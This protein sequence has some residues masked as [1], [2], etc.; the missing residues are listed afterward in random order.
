VFADG[1][2][3]EA[4]QGAGS[5]AGL[6]DAGAG[7]DVGHGDDLAGVLGVDDGGA[8]GH[9][10]GEV[11]QEGPEDEVFDVAGGADDDALGPADDVVVADPA[12]VA[13]PLLAGL[14][15]QGVDPALG[16]GQ[17]HLVAVP[18]DAVRGPGRVRGRRVAGGHP[19]SL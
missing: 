11:L 15:G 4:G 16:V 5:G 2:Q 12:L 9:A 10:D 19:S 6:D 14:Q 17:L 13:V 18:E 8:A 1:A 7:E 3:Q